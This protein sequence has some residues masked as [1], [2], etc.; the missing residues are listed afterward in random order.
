MP[1]TLRKMNQ[2]FM[3]NE[4]NRIYPTGSNAGRFY[5]TSK[6]DK[7]QINGTVD[8]LLISPILSSIDTASYQPDKYLAELL[9]LSIQ[10]ECTLNSKSFPLKSCPCSQMQ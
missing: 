3:F 6:V 10:S 2:K 4:Y 9:S 7:V 8:E 5:G 1:C